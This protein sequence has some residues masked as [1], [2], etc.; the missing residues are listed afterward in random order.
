MVSQKNVYLDEIQEDNLN[1]LCNTRSSH[2]N[3]RV[4]HHER[5]IVEHDPY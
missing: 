3:H 5:E 4:K 1:H 2:G